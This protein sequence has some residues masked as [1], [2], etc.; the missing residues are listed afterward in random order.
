[1]R[2]GYVLKCEKRKTPPPGQDND[3]GLYYFS[4]INTQFH[5][6]LSVNHTPT[7]VIKHPYR[8]HIKLAIFYVITNR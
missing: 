7:H 1:M 4:P 5:T 2:C 3:E 6:S 8:P